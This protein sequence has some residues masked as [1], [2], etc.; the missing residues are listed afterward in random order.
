MLKPVMA[1]LRNIRGSFAL[2]SFDGRYVNRTSFVRKSKETK[3]V[4]YC[5]GRRDEYDKSVSTPPSPSDRGR[6]RDGNV[7]ERARKAAIRL[8]A[9][10]GWAGFTF[11]AVAREAGVGKSALYRRWGSKEELLLETL[12]TSI[13]PLDSI[14]SGTVRGDLVAYVRAELR[15]HS[16]ASGRVWVR[17][18]VESASHPELLE[19]MYTRIVAQ[20][21]EAALAIVR[22][23]VA[24]GELPATTPAPLL[25]HTLFGAVMSRIFFARSGLRA[26]EAA[27]DSHYAEQLVDFV[28]AAVCPAMPARGAARGRES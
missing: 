6:P 9:R 7:D 28:L 10:D 5:R 19:Q 27:D 12:E 2:R 21:V 15:A 25:F 16:S 23:A 26:P 20:R 11:D 14:D 3:D 24:R 1:I 13:E 17:I 22:R 18:F 8:Y 4:R